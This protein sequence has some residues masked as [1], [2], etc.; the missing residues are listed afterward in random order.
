LAGGGVL[1]TITT[2]PQ[3]GIER[4]NQ[5]IAPVYD[6]SPFY[7]SDR[8]SFYVERRVPYPRYMCY[9]CHNPWHWDPYYAICPAFEI[10]IFSRYDDY[11]YR[12]PYNPWGRRPYYWYKRKLNREYPTVKYKY[13]SGREYWTGRTKAKWTYP[14]Q[15]SKGDRDGDRRN[16]GDDDR[17]KDITTPD[18]PSAPDIRIKNPPREERSGSRDGDS[19]GTRVRSPEPEKRDKPQTPQPDRQIQTRPYYREKEPERRDEG[20]DKPQSRPQQSDSS[21]SRQKE[22]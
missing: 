15:P 19:D 21:A 17:W 6:G 22:K 13:S 20:R 3:M 16:R 10:V 8:T 2:D 7:V 11:Y 1:E 14:E 5:L 9:D 4:I 18:R 12:P